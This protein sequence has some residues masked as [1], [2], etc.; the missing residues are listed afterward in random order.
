MAIGRSARSMRRPSRTLVLDGDL[1]CRLSD[2]MGGTIPLVCQDWTNSKTAHRFFVNPKVEDDDILAGHFAATKARY[3]LPQ[4]PI[5]LI[6]DTT[7]FT[8]QR[9]NPHDVGFTKSVN[10]GRDKEGR[11]R[12]H[13]VCGILMHSSLVVTQEGLPLG[14]CAVKLWNR[15]K[16]KGTA[17][18]KRKLNQTRVPIEAKES[19]RWLDN[20]RQSID[21]LGEPER[22]AHGSDRESDIYELYCVAKEGAWHS[23]RSPHRSRPAC[24]QRGAHR[25][26]R[27]ARGSRSGGRIASR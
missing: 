26:E 16:F 10:S 4:G 13:A 3:A 9:R 27:N 23:L 2:R 1:L 22:C 5:L 8:Y 6:Q 18:L 14:L 21:F 20:L 12:H 7:E 24:S 25:E 15:D 19:V 11:L 17:Q